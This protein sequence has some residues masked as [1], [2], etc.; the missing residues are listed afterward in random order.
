MPAKSLRDTLVES[1]PKEATFQHLFNEAM[2]ANHLRF[3]NFIIPKLNTFTTNAD[4]DI[5]TGELDFYINCELQ[6]C[7]ELLRKDD[8]IGEHHLR[9]DEYKDPLV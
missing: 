9:F 6:W 3:D 4:V 5:V 7:L 8:K 2:S 1:F